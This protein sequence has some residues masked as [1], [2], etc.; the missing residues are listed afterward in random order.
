MLVMVMTTMTR[1]EDRA[2]QPRP[3]TYRLPKPG[4][5]DPFWGFSRSFYYRGEELGYWRLIR[6]CESGKDRG[7]TLVES[8]QVARFVARQRKVQKEQHA[9]VVANG[10]DTVEKPVANIGGQHYARP[11]QFYEKQQQQKKLLKKHH[12]KLGTL[13]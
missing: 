10:G 7:V 9:E 5:N 8:D 13:S 12:P 6:I 11:P 3:I 2:S 4:G 1:G